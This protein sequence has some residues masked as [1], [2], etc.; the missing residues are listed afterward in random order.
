MIRLPP[1]K[2]LDER[3]RNNGQAKLVFCDEEAWLDSPKPTPKKPLPPLKK[4]Q[5]VKTD[6]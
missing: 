4:E 3:Q 1:T 5:N 2:C 6:I